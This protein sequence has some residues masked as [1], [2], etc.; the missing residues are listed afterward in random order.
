MSTRKY[1]DQELRELS[2]QLVEMAS[3]AVE[4]VNRALE[5]LKTYDRTLA[6]EVVHNDGAINTLER[7]I[8]QRCLKLLLMQQPV[9]SD[10][11]Q[12]SAT[13]KMITDIERIGD[14]A[15]DIAEL[16]LHHSA[17]SI[18]QIREQVLEMA[19]E[20]VEM[21]D[22]AVTSY[23]T[24]DLDLARATEK[25]DDVVDEWFVRLR[26]TLGQHLLTHPEAID[27]IVDYL[28]IIKYLERVGDH[29]VNL[30]EWVEFKIT[31]QYKREEMF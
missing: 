13:M 28:M 10:L 14:E 30:C 18:P 25:R 9:A 8:E 7:I 17:C 2:S 26:K 11:R 27:E 1:Y 16:S 24:D 22:A 19:E 15:V 4:A 20:A 3:K 31:G 23:I 21:V 29:G 12:V 5:T 6:E